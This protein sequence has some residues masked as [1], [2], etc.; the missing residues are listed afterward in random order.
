MTDRSN[1]V[2]DQSRKVAIAEYLEN[3]WAADRRSGTLNGE[4]G[5]MEAQLVGM[6]ECED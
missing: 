2:P 4:V 3:P 1:K 5:R 6:E